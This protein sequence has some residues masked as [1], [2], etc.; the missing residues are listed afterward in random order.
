M[1]N[2]C[3]QLSTIVNNC[4]QLS[5]IV[6]NCQ[7][8]SVIVNNCQQL[9]AIVSNCQE[10]VI[11]K[12]KYFEFSTD[13]FMQGQP[14][15]IGAEFSTSSKPGGINFVFLFSMEELRYLAPISP[16]LVHVPALACE[17]SPPRLEE[18]LLCP[19]H[20]S[21]CQVLGHFGQQWIIDKRLPTG[22]IQFSTIY[23]GLAWFDWY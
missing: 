20:V 9:S 7:Q 14:D 3:Q 21:S 23:V 17:L 6:S 5:T 22:F 18:G 4:Q 15:L 19:C 2:N 16:F 1:L 10:D 11:K 13:K 12:I 8:L